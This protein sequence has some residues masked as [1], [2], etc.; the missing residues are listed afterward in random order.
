MP[1]THLVVQAALNYRSRKTIILDDLRHLG[2]GHI[3]EHLDL[4]RTDQI[5]HVNLSIPTP[6]NTTA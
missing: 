1:E 5:A 3:E 6:H 2:C 4:I